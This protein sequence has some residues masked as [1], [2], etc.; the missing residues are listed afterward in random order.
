MSFGWR[1]E[2]GDKKY[3]TENNVKVGLEFYVLN[4]LTFLENL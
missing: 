3:F 4:Q 2:G 1:N